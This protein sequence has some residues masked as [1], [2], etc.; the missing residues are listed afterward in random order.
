MFKKSISR[1]LCAFA[2]LAACAVTCAAQSA[3]LI[4]NVPPKIPGVM[5]PHYIKTGLYYLSGGGSNSVLRLSGNG[6]LLVDG[7]HANNYA[8][9]RLRVKK[10]S[11][12][13]IVALINT[14]HYED[15]TGT[16]AKFL[17]DHVP[18][19]AQQNEK[20]ILVNYNP[21]GGKI[22]PPTDTFDRDKDLH[23]GPVEVQL[24]HFGNA[25]TGGDT[26]VYFTDLKAV[27][28]GDI[29]SETPNPDYS[30]GGSLLDWGPVLGDVLKLD[31]NVAVPGEGHVASKADVEAFKVKIDTLVSRAHQLV[32]SGVPKDRFMA[33]LKTDD[34]GWKLNFSPEQVDGFYSEL[35]RSK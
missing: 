32:K 8:E 26:V 24:F 10:I 21:P 33:Q 28:L 27:A 35:S 20:Q 2:M 7:K 25:C 4:E 14:D 3:A 19:L 31:F 15:R 23:L 34:L 29:Y 9:L 22:P 6:L 12:Q 13:E 5:A 18:V 16:N 30:A 17:E 11:S 1:N